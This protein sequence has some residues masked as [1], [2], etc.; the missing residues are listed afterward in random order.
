MASA[1][2]HRSYLF[3][4]LL[5][6]VLELAHHADGRGT[7]EEET[8]RMTRNNSRLFSKQARVLLSCPRLHSTAMFKKKSKVPQAFSPKA[9]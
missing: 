4:E 6:V 8:S 2:A 7:R 1:A 5:L 3:E 9:I